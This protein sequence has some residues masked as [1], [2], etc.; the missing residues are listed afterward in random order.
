MEFSVQED[1]DC[2]YNKTRSGCDGGCES[3]A[4]NFAKTHGAVPAS[5]DPYEGKY[6]SADQCTNDAK[7]K[8]DN[9]M[10][11]SGFGYI[12]NGDCNAVKAAL[13]K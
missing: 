11:V 7:Y 1:I 3:K 12:G 10:F 13:A 2:A 6:N 5:N 4:Y 9:K 8:T